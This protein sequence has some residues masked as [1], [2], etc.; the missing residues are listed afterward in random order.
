MTHDYPT[1][2]PSDTKPSPH[3]LQ[4]FTPGKLS[5]DLVGPNKLKLGPKPS[6]AG[7]KRD[8][9]LAFG[10]DEEPELEPVPTS[11]FPKQIPPEIQMDMSF[12]PAL[13]QNSAIGRM[14]NEEEKKKQ[15][16]KLISSIPT[17]KE[18]VFKY[19]LSWAMIDKVRS[20]MEPVNNGHTRVRLKCPLGTDDR[21]TQVDYDVESRIG[22]YQ[23]WPLWTGDHSW[24]FEPIN[25]R[26]TR[27]FWR[28][29]EVKNVQILVVIIFNLVN[30]G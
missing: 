19:D 28:I 2:E 8:V 3:P 1:T 16:K 29:F 30:D 20:I 9:D 23:T 26:L 25:W 14:L 11:K 13:P 24:R 6:D 18:E 15:T 21:C 17:S 22:T 10:V 7:R 12:P 27:Y 5:F 4:N